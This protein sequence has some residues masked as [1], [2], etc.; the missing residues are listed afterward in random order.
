MASICLLSNQLET[1][2]RHKLVTSGGFSG[3][4]RIAM[5]PG[6]NP[7]SESFLDK[8]S[9]CYP[10]SGDGAFTKQFCLEYKWEKKGCGDLIICLLIPSTCSLSLLMKVLQL[11]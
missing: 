9:S 7:K 2:Q 4:I 10:V 6:S 1:Y 8:F 5:L 11:V 3:I